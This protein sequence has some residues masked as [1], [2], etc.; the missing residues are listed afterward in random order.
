LAEQDRN[1]TVLVPLIHRKEISHDT[2]LL[3]FGL[4]TE[5]HLLGLPIG[6]CV[7]FFCPNVTGDVAGEWNKRPDPEAELEEI[8]RKYTPCSAWKQKGS[9]DMIIKVRPEQSD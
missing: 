8:E 3:R 9:F 5:Q 1:K 2:V 6:M 4:P 7:K